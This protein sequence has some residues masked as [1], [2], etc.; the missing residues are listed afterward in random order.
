VTLASLAPTLGEA[1]ARLER[2]LEGGGSG[3]VV[4]AA[5]EGSQSGGARMA[6]RQVQKKDA[7]DSGDS[8]DARRAL[9]D[10]ERLG[11]TMFASGSRRSPSEHELNAEALLLFLEEVL[12]QL[13]PQRLRDPARTV[14]SDGARAPQPRAADHRGGGRASAG[15]RDPLATAAQAF[16][17]TDLLAGLQV[18][19]YGLRFARMRAR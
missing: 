5:N 4:T 2:Y 18:P 10:D 14:L 11:V 9:S 8:G 13:D 12:P 19:C 17:G 6:P 7:V 3:P 15:S 1:E 16:H